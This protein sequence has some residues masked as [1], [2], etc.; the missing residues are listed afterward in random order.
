M[1]HG[2]IFTLW[3]K[4]C[5]VEK[6]TGMQ[7]QRHQ[8]VAPLRDP[9][10]EHEWVG[11]ELLALSNRIPIHSWDLT[12]SSP[13]KR[14]QHRIHATTTSHAMPPPQPASMATLGLRCSTAAD[15]RCTIQDAHKTHTRSTYDPLKT[16]VRST[17][18]TYKIHARSAQ[19]YTRS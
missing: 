13:S 6:H 19:A 3:K 17:D 12:G 15:C 10:P 2:K 1:P 4:N 8:L 5:L 11:V 14:N 16:H 7:T 18:T 9:L